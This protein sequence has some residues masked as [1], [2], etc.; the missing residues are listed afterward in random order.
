MQTFLFKGHRNS[1]SEFKMGGLSTWC[2]EFDIFH[3][4]EKR[5]VPLMACAVAYINLKTSNIET[6]DIKK[7]S[8]LSLN[9]VFMLNLVLTHTSG[10]V[11]S[12]VAGAS[13]L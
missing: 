8:F 12:T 10:R 13:A 5:P 1:V 2:Q 4:M 6:W 3:M 7:V 9:L 11:L